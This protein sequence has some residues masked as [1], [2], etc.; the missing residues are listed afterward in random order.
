MTTGA[1]WRQLAERLASE[2]RSGERAPG[3]R[4]PS[5]ADLAK[6]GLS[7][8]TVQRAYGLLSMEGL[9]NAVHGAGTFVADP[10]PAQSPTSDTSGD[11]TRRLDDHEQRIAKL[12]ELMGR[13]ASKTD[14]GPDPSH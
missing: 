10:V 7:Q 12:E 4:L 5:F 6:E 13:I 3:S 11:H 2:I 9:A 1:L 14:T 8:A